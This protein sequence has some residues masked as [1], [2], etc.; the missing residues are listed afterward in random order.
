MAWQARF[1]NPRFQS[2]PS[3]DS[4]RADEVPEER[5]GICCFLI[6]VNRLYFGLLQDPLEASVQKNP[7]WPPTPA[8][9]HK[10]T[11]ELDEDGNIDKDCWVVVSVFQVVIGL[12]LMSLAGTNVC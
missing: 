10:D 2:M 12:V 1:Y 3:T 8:F 5:P 9:D 11:E 4:L 7:K 6:P